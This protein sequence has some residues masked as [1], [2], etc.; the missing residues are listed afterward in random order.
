MA[1]SPGRTHASELRFLYTSGEVAPGTLEDGVF[2]NFGDAG[3]DANGR[4]V[5]QGAL[6]GAHFNSQN[7]TGIWGMQDGQTTLLIQEGRNLELGKSVFLSNHRVTGIAD[8]GGLV[9]SAE[10]QGN[11]ATGYAILFADSTGVATPAVYFGPVAGQTPNTLFGGAEAQ[12]SAAGQIYGRVQLIGEDVNSLNDDTIWT[13]DNGA[14]GELFAREGEPVIGLSSPPATWSMFNYLT[15][16]RDGMIAART[17]IIDGVT[18]ESD[19]NTLLTYTPP[20]G[21]NRAVSFLDPVP[22]SNSQFG[23]LFVPA[24]IEQG[25]LGF[26]GFTGE[27]SAAGIFTYDGL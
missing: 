22:N 1:V 18:I 21:W 26:Y 17:R 15:V 7:D 11:D 27:P 13:S 19:Y 9:I 8:A 24:L 16:N 10:T 25:T 6:L 12:T 4:I 14:P 20:G 23:E 2:Y 3:F 5:F